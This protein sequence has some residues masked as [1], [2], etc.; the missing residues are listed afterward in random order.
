MDLEAA[1]QAAEE[2]ERDARACVHTFRD[3]NEAERAYH[4]N[5]S[6]HAASILHSEANLRVR[7]E[8]RIQELESELSSLRQEAH[9]QQPFGGAKR[10]RVEAQ[11]E[12]VQAQEYEEARQDTRISLAKAR[13]DAERERLNAERAQ[14]DVA[15][16]RS[17]AE[18]AEQREAKLLEQLN[19]LSYRFSELSGSTGSPDSL[20]RSNQGQRAAEAIEEAK[21]LR[22][23]AEE[24]AIALEDDAARGRELAGERQR[25]EAL[26]QELAT[27]RG[28]ASRE[29][30]LQS[31]KNET[32]TVLAEALSVSSKE[33]Y[34]SLAD[35]AR[36]VADALMQHQQRALSAE[37]ES[38]SLNRKLEDLNDELASERSARAKAEARVQYQGTVSSDVK[39]QQLQQKREDEG[40][41]SQEQLQNLHEA[42]ADSRNA[43]ASLSSQKTWNQ[44]KGEKAAA[45]EE[46]RRLESE[47]M[48]LGKLA[49]QAE[50]R[51]GK[52]AFDPRRTKVLHMRSNPETQTR[53]RSVSER[54]EALKQENESLKKRLEGTEG[55]AVSGSAEA[56]VKEAEATVLKKKVSELEKREKRLREVFREQVATFKDAVWHMLGWKIWLAS[57]PSAG[58]HEP[59]VFKLQSM[60][61]T[62]STELLQF[63]YHPTEAVGRR[64]ELMWNDF[65]QTG[66]VRKQAEIFISRYK[67]PPGLTSNLLLEE[68]NKHS[69]V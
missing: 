68:F 19:D 36:A 69:M 56:S 54:E 13:E 63:R 3:L 30:E 55:G 64:A 22:K 25:R 44:L 59:S 48:R 66:E 37:K 2:R 18:S 67:C 29:R 7:K 57:A 50:R 4:S 5:D 15:E 16:L 33:Q 32:H 31:E 65:A 11:T 9:Q 53:L 52:G 51:L 12:P 47:V 49:E 27:E 60:F 28:A 23:Q 40:S 46:A 38:S 21:K 62:S 41:E 35:M 39:G 6:A 61:A 17:R 42:A 26:E 8:Q 58:S 34:N 20:E 24:R 10:A 1:L 43:D 14:Q 45:E